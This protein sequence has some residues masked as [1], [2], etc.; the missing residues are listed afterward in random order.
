MAM[1]DP[2][3]NGKPT[4]IGR[5][6]IGTTYAKAFLGVAENSGRAEPLVQEFNELVTQVLERFPEFDRTLSSPRVSVE[7]KQVLLDRVL[8]GRVSDELL[9]F[10]QVVG[11]HGRLDCLREIRQAAI[12]LFQTSRGIV[13][14]HVTAAAPLGAELQQRIREALNQKLGRSVEL[15]VH[16]DPEILGGIVVRV[17]DTVFDGS[18]AN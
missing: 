10:L 17:G 5:G 15:K 9:R 7:E 14:V 12:E 8:G 16:F 4:D 11:Q 18:I 3:T 13:T 6:R 2:P 1:S